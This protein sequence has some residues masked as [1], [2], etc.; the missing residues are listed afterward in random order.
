MSL[1]IEDL[2]KA[3]CN[4][5]KIGLELLDQLYINKEMVRG[6]NLYGDKNGKED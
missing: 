4:G 2:E 3:S 5:H 6:V 1:S